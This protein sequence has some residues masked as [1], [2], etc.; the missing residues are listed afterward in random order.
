M[1][2]YVIF[3]NPKTNKTI[4]RTRGGK[5]SVLAVPES[6][7]LKTGDLISGKLDMPGEVRVVNLTQRQMFP[8]QI[9][10]AHSDVA[11]KAKQKASA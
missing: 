3:T 2:G 4:V 11:S 9:Q 1:D 8:A 7:S 6:V 10:L 5:Y